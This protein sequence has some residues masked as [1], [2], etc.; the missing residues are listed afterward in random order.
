MVI[1]DNVS[2]RADPHAVLFLLLRT[3]ETH[4]PVPCAYL[5]RYQMVRLLESYGPFEVGFR[6]VVYREDDAR[7]VARNILMQFSDELA[8]Q[9]ERLPALNGE[10]DGRFWKGLEEIARSHTRAEDADKNPDQQ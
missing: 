7:L 9:I 5:G 10:I 6:L 8:G 4:L 2:I 3:E 1:A